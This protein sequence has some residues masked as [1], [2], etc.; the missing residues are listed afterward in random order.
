MGRVMRVDLSERASQIEELPESICSDFVGSRGIGA[1]LLRDEVP[2]GSDPFGPEN[3]LIF[4]TAPFNGTKVICS[5][6][7]CCLAKSPLN[8]FYGEA[9]SSAGRIGEFLKTN[10]VDGLIIEGHA[11]APTYLVIANGQVT[12]RSA[13]DVWGLPTTAAAET[14]KSQTGGA[15]VAVIGPAGE[16]LSPL[17]CVKAEKRSFG[18]TGLGAVMGSKNLK[19][20]AV[21]RGPE[22]VAVADPETLSALVKEFAERIEESE[23]TSVVRRTYGTTHMLETINDEGMLPT[24]NFQQ[25]VF[26]GAPNLTHHAFA[27]TVKFADG[28]CSRCTIRCEKTSLVRSGP[29]AGATY[30]GPE[31]ETIWAFGPQCG[32][33]SLESI[34]EINRVCSELGMDTISAGSTI[35]FAMECIQRDLLHDGDFGFSLRWGDDEAILRLLRMM[36]YREGY[37]DLLCRGTR[38]AAAEIGG[39]SET[40]AMQV[41]GLELPAYDPRGT[42]GFGLALAT[43]SRGACHLRAFTPMIELS[44][45]GGGRFSPEGKAEL[46]RDDQDKRAAYEATG[47]CFTASSVGDEEFFARLLGAVTGEEWDGESLLRVGERTYN[48]ERL[49][50]MREGLG[51]GDDTLPERLFADPVPE[52]PVAG[53]KIER[54]DFEQM[55]AEYYELRGWDAETGA[56]TGSKLE[57]LGVAR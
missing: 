48:V 47:V 8:G 29:Y 6:R 38:T 32:N 39:E 51:R 18:R 36:A 42:I 17:A 44:G 41:K 23:F 50:A 40:F 46:V 34:I 55:L 3:R 15:Q 35:G 25:A 10:G 21:H 1:R 4:M 2:A 57:E 52:G 53:R 49:L 30:V 37:G 56:P 7:V 28:A 45:W 13:R 26:E 27:K 9:S 16:K 54:D 22:A 24:R 19:A 14:I 33:G 11:D 20:I 31:W 12:F 43:S 5:P